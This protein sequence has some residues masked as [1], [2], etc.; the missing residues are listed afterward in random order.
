MKRFLSKGE[1]SS[2]PR[3]VWSFCQRR[4]PKSNLAAAADG[5]QQQWRAAAVPQIVARRHK[6][7]PLK[8]GNS[9]SSTWKSGP[10]MFVCSSFGLFV[11]PPVC[12]SAFGLFV[13]LRSVLARNNNNWSTRE[14]FGQFESGALHL[15]DWLVRQEELWRIPVYIVLSRLLEAAPLQH[16]SNWNRSMR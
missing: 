3:P 6:S 11:R 13:C 10:K 12:L 15:V 14:S 2:L 9:C 4:T 5:M 8:R 16:S 1:R 7:E